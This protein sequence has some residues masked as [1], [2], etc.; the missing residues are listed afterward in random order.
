MG[1][2]IFQ[3][4]GQ[5]IPAKQG[6]SIAAAL[7]AAHQPVLGARRSGAA[8]GVFCGM[9][10]CHD[11]LVTVDGLRGQRACMT[12]V[13]AE[14][15]VSREEERAFALGTQ[16]PCAQVAN[17]IDAE[18]AIIGAGPAGLSAAVT[19]ASAGADVVVLDE[20]DTPG[21]QY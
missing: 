11:C 1:D 18:I 5:A 8:R 10:I 14:M 13:Q 16:P 12:E 15:V 4:E 2:M 21:G 9:G 20:R 17:K 19:A 7:A 3:F 6:D